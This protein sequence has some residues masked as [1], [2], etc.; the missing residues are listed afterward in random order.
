MDILN[1]TL[2]KVHNF[3][4]T[5]ILRETKVGT[6]EIEIQFFTK[7]D[8]LFCQIWL[9]SKFCPFEIVKITIIYLWDTLKC[10]L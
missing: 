10:N 1:F 9:D 3:T 4:V 6:C 7:I 8:I 2:W 5:Q